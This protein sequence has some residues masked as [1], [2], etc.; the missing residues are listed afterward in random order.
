[1][2]NLLSYSKARFQ[3]FTKTKKGKI[4]GILLIAV[5]LFFSVTLYM[6]VT[7]F[8]CL[9]GDCENGFAKIQYRGGSYYEGYVKNSHPD[10]YG[11]FKNEEGHL[12]RGEWKRG[13]KQGKGFYRYP[14]GSSYS[15]F[16]LNNKKHGIGQFVWRDGSTLNSRW[17]E[18]KPDGAGRLIL[19]DGI[20]LDG[21]YRSGRIF[22]GKGAFI[23]PNGNIYIG[24]WR[25][26]KREGYGILQDESGKIIYK[27]NWK[28]DIEAPNS[29]KE[30]EL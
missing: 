1:M 16:F 19:T 24:S 4:Y 14:D 12:Y 23:Y 27:G 21:V 22:D 8:E 28:K 18:D 2:L 29:K 26:G 15:G 13:Q 17:N 20:K 10:G 5:I 3:I 7:R 9:S 11:L 30:N 25:A 6:R